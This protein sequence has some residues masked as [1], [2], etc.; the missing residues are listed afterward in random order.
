LSAINESENTA[1][2]DFVWAFLKKGL[3][4]KLIETNLIELDFNPFLDIVKTEKSPHEILGSLLEELNQKNPDDVITLVVDEANIPLTMNDN[5]SE[6]IKEVS[7]YLALFT[8]L[9]KEEKKVSE[10]LMYCNLIFI[11]YVIDLN[12]RLMSFWC[13]LS[14][15][16]PSD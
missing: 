7:A 14:M 3:A 12:F 9:T 8:K 11:F 2:K 15:F 16:S 5:T 6:E 10:L 4:S 13:P 1:L